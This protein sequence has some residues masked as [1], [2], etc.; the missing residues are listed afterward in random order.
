[1]SPPPSGRRPF[2]KRFG[3]DFIMGTMDLTL[4]ESGAYSKLLDMMYDRGGPIPDEPRWIAGFLNCSTRKWGQLRESLLAAGKLVQ[5]GDR[6][7]NPRMERELELAEETHREA[8]KWGRLGGKK[9]AE[10]DAEARRIA[11]RLAEPELALGD[12]P[13][14]ISGK[15]ARKREINGAKVERVAEMPE[16]KARISADLGQAPLNHARATHIPESREESYDSSGRGLEK[17]GSGQ[18]RRLPDGW[19][20]EPLS[21]SAQA[22]VARWPDGM[23]A[24]EFERFRDHW[25]AQPGAKG[26]KSDWNATWRNWIRKADDD[27]KRFGARQ[28][29]KPSGWNF[30]GAGR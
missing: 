8:V 11:A 18:G 1:M 2:Y 21:D 5:R 30:G 6:L 3:G 28:Q 16:Q 26:R 4:E 12:E 13:A 14:I 27:W 20:P 22:M 19:E 7:S 24:R 25:L 23:V 15:S 9:R 17:A 10:A 29:G